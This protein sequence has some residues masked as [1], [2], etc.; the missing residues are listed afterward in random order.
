MRLQG[1]FQAEAVSRAKAKRAGGRLVHAR[2]Q[3]GWL[4]ENEL[5]KKW[6]VRSVGEGKAR[7]CGLCAVSKFRPCCKYE[8]KLLKRS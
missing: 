1:V 8:G 4:E 3:V 7:C 6:Q 2:S 5:G